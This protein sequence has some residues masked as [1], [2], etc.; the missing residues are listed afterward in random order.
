METQKPCVIVI[1]YE[2]GQRMDFLCIFHPVL[3][4]V[5]LSVL[6]CK[7]DTKSCNCGPYCTKQ[8]EYRLLFTN[9]CCLYVYAHHVCSTMVMVT[10]HSYTWKIIYY[11]TNLQLSPV[12]GF[13]CESEKV[14]SIREALDFFWKLVSTQIGL[15]NYSTR[16]KLGSLTGQKFSHSTINA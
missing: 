15:S 12:L 4:V 6:Q 11:N 16:I 2:S 7:G 1:C 13:I 3:S 10:A 14:N 8:W 9:K 5:A